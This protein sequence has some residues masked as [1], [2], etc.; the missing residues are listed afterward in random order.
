MY[1]GQ[2]T[3]SELDKICP[4][5]ILKQISTISMHI[6]SLVKIHSDL[7]KFSSIN[8]NTDVLRTDNSVKNS[9][10]FP[11]EIPNQVST[12]SMHT[13]SLV[14]I[15]W[16]LLKSSSGNENTEILQADNS[17]K[18]WRNLPIYNS[19][20]DLHNINAHIKFG[21]N[22]LKFTQVIVRKWKY[23]WTDRH[24]MDRQMDRHTDSQRDTIIPPTIV[25]QGIKS[26]YN[27]LL[28]SLY[29]NNVCRLN[30]CKHVIFRQA[31][32]GLCF[33]VYGIIGVDVLP[34]QS[35]GVMSSVV[36]LP[37]HTFTGQA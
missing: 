29:K 1:C 18:Y 21:E 28:I 22:P 31:Y 4:L 15:H 17:V 16:Y 35:N 12:I 34:S 20:P 24:M 13:P 10:I 37:N 23:R 11:S 8:E 19:K 6:P 30:I 25:W 3:L 9:E 32:S 36:R 2:I 27:F 7:L 14:K 26:V 5:A 33:C